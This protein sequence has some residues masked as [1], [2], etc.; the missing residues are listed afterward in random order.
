MNISN[1]KFEIIVAEA[2]DNL[3]DKFKKKL[4]NVAILVED[5]PSAAQL[6]KLGVRGDYL[7]FGL[8]EG[9]IQSKRLNFGPVLPD[10]ITIFKK[11]I[12]SQSADENDLRKKI[13]STV[14]HEIAHHFGS[15][16]PGARK[17][18]RRNS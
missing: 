6:K 7:L 16:E 17:A 5:C 11:A 8:F 13:E 14:R 1:E 15:D 10:R 2:I 18:S 9:Y 3:P 4:N 12:S